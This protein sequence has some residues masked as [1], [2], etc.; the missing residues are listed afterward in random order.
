MCGI[1]TF[2]MLVSR[3]SRI[4]ASV[5]VIAMIQRCGYEGSSAR[6]E[7]NSAVADDMGYFVTTVALTLMP[8]R[9]GC[10]A[11]NGPSTRMRTGIRCTTFVKFPVALSGGSSEKRAPVAGL[12]LSTWPVNFRPGYASRSEEQTPEL[13]SPYVISYAAFCLKK[14]TAH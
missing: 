10:A 14:K 1:A 6:V 12:R 5:T 11:S 7:S 4:D 13:Q 3:I 2:T 9:S 8:G